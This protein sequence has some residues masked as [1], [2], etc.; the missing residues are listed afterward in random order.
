MRGSRSEAYLWHRVAFFVLDDDFGSY[1]G[2]PNST[3][4]ATGKRLAHASPEELAQV[5]EGLNEILGN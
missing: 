4:T 3:L 1:A 2:M 5:L